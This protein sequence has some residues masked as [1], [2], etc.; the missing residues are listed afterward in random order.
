[1]Q[2]RLVISLTPAIKE[3]IHA[4]VQGGCGDPLNKH[5][6]HL[7]FVCWAVVYAHWRP[8]GLHFT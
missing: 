2:M 4:V 7:P 5:T 1:M 3:Y 6:H 8:A